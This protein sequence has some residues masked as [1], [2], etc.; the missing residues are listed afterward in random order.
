M[1]S[2]ATANPVLTGHAVQFMRA[3][4]GYVGLTLFPAFPSAE[5]SA[6]YYI[7]TRENALNVP[8]NIRHAPGAPFPRSVPKISD[9]LYACQD[10]G[11]EQP[12]PDEIR[13]KYANYIDADISAVRRNT[14]ILKINHEL[15]AHTLAT[16]AG[17][18]NSGVA[19]KWDDPDSDPKGDVDAAKEA[20]RKNTGQRPTVMVISE[21]VRLVLSVHPKIAER[22]KYTTTGITSLEL[23]AAYFEVG[24]IVVAEQVINTA[25]E[26]QALT[27]ADIWGDDVLLALVN[28]ARDLMVPTF[29]RTFWW[30][31]FGSIGADDVPIQIVSYRDETVASDVHRVRHF[32]DE[33]IVFDKAAYRINDVLT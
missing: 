4:A 33:K 26:G 6:N 27:P 10:Y 21:A 32:T 18:P 12:V 31:D 22:V 30:S 25:N 23:L 9:D 8:R 16:G 28:P 14:D 2:N 5:Q 11:L 13:R 15:R 3:T 7:W 20:I 17:V 1:I 29:G 19:K 24:K